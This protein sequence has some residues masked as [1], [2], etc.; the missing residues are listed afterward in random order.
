MTAA[1]DRYRR[2]GFSYQ[3]VLS[4]RV[5]GGDDNTDDIPEVVGRH[6]LLGDGLVFFPHFGFEPGTLYRARFAPPHD[7]AFDSCAPLSLDIRLNLTSTPPSKVL[8]VFPSGDQLPENLLRIYLSFSESMRR[9]KADAQISIV[10]PDGSPTPDILYRAP[11]EL[12][13]REMR[14]LTVLLDPG[15]IKRG[16]GPNRRLGPPLKA[17]H[18]YTLI[19]GAGMTDRLGQHLPETFSKRFRATEAV[20]KA[21]E[22]DEWRVLAPVS[23]TVEPLQ[24][25]FPA[26]LDR[27]MLDYSIR[28]V[29]RQSQPLFG[30]H[31]IGRDE[32]QWS[33]MPASPWT[34]G[35]YRVVVSSEL[36]DVCGN[37]L[38]G[39]F[40][41]DVS[42]SAEPAHLQPR[43]KSIRFLL[44]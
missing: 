40:D 39:P 23:G 21:I 30:H 8:A 33:F 1:L 20:R 42:L 12:W 24:L 28:V 7:T 22:I 35:E 13:D 10:G 4:V 36:E 15:R 17:G 26:A 2:A 32:K 37:D 34:V 25:I 6:Q 29:N 31:E 43:T 3:S 11:V 5:V 38:F 18:E 27:G 19:V 14:C 44:S 16:A 41:R 9:G